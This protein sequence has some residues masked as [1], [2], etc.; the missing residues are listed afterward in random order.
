[1]MTS[2]R[3]GG[4]KI[5]RD[6]QWISRAQPDEDQHFPG[7]FCHVLAGQNINLDYLTYGFFDGVC[8]LNSVFHDNN[9][10]IVEN[11]LSKQFGDWNSPISDA[12]ILSVF[13]HKKDPHVTASL[14][15]IFS[16]QNIPPNALANSNSA[17]SAVLPKNILPD[18][19]QALFEPFSFSAYRTPADWKLAQKGKEQLYKE[20]VASYQEK[21]PKV[22][23]LQWQANQELFY[24]RHQQG[25]S[26]RVAAMFSELSKI[27]LSITFLISGPLNENDTIIIFCLPEGKKN[28]YESIIDFLPS[29]LVAERRPSVAYFSM[30]GPHFGDRYGIASEL[31]NVLQ[32]AGN[33]LIGLSCSIASITGIL[34]GEQIQD[35]LKTIEECFEVP[36]VI[37]LP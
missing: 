32:K 37:E 3:L 2:A 17:I 9:F 15:K 19:T 30:N 36:S 35:G 8:S 27:E 7:L 26:G 31:I 29:G 21:K 22:Y 13:P 23:A 5:L 6:V 4:F 16:Q 11:S 34:P 10:E 20:V 33:P 28:Q 25:F 12:V 14:L 18:V 1:M 24:L